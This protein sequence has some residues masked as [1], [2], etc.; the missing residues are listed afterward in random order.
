MFTLPA[1]FA[2]QAVNGSDRDTLPALLPSGAP[3]GPSPLHAEDI[4]IAHQG[5]LLAGTLLMPTRETASR[6]LVLL[7]SGSGPTDRDGN[8]GGVGS[9][10]LRMLAQELSAEGYPSFRF[11]KRGV[12]ESLFP[13]LDE[14]KLLFDTF[15]ADVLAWLNY[16]QR[17]ARFDGVVLIGHSEGALLA[18]LAAQTHEQVRGLVSLAGAG[19]P[20]DAVILQQLERQPPFVRESADSLFRQLRAG[21]PL[22]PPPFMEALFRPSV[23]PFMRSWMQYDPAAELSDLTMPVLI[24]GGSEDLQIARE[25]ADRLISMAVN[26]KMVWIPGMNHVLKH[27]TNLPENYVSYTDSSRLLHPELVPA[28]TSWLRENIAGN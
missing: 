16:W 13:G 15:V 2:G 21:M 1:L 10:A 23:L 14:E 24:L 17:D 18:K 7:I 12:G 4:R 28:L 8:Q 26:G 9:A 19:R 3:S 25:D 22:N 27:V 20:V 6:T 5:G 11:D